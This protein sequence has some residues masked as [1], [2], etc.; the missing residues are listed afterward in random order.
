MRRDNQFDLR[1]PVTEEMIREL[2]WH[3]LVPEGMVMLGELN[4]AIGRQED[5]LGVSVEGCRITGITVTTENGT[6]YA[7]IEYTRSEG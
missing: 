3:A 5:L 7:E 6:M 4:S 1:I 2:L